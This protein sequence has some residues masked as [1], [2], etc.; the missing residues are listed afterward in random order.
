MSRRSSIVKS[1]F[2]LIKDNLLFFSACSLLCPTDHP[3]LHDR[4]DL[5]LVAALARSQ[6]EAPEHEVR[7]DQS[8]ARGENG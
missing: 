3:Q 8:F 4:Q 2:D 5:A 7:R 6:A 1:I